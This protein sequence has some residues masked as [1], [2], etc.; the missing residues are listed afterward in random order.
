MSQAL[1]DT[2]VDGASALSRQVSYEGRKELSDFKHCSSLKVKV[3]GRDSGGFNRS[4]VDTSLNLS[5]YAYISVSKSPSY[6]LCKSVSSD[7]LGLYYVNFL[8]KVLS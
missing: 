5:G 6:C 7:H 8:T 2:E 3:R 1:T 4:P